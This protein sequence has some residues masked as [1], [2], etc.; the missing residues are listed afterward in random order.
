MYLKSQYHSIQ[1]G[2]CQLICS[3]DQHRHDK[4]WDKTYTLYCFAEHMTIVWHARDSI[5]F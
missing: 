5:F 4:I 3:L 2:I 1:L